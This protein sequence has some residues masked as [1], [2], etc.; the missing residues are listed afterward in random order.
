VFLVSTVLGT[1]VAVAT[2]TFIPAWLGTHR[3]P[4]TAKIS[5]K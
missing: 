2:V 3:G 1:V 4:V 5:G